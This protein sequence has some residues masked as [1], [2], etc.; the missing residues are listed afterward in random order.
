MVQYF[1]VFVCITNNWIK[2]QSFVYT[3]FKDYRSISKI[4]FGKSTKLN[5]PKYYNASPTIWF[6]SSHLYKELNNQTVLFQPFSLA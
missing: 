6:N 3:Q 4:Q 5:S 1:Q 2:H